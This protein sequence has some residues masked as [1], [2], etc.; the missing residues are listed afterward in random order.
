MG[1]DLGNLVNETI[2]GMGDFLK[3]AIVAAIGLQ[4]KSVRVQSLVTGGIA[5]VALLLLLAFHRRR[6]SLPPARLA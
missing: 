1:T 3:E 6:S 4:M 2:K 5:L